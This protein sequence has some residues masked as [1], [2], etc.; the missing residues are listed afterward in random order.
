MGKGKKNKPVTE[1]EAYRQ[2]AETHKNAVPA[3]LV[4]HLYGLTEEEFAYILTT[5]PLVPAPVKDAALNAYTD[6]EGGLIK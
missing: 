5:F 1:I 3:G 6:V 4:A 2:E